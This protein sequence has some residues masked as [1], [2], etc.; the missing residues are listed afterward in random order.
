MDSDE[1]VFPHRLQ[2]DPVLSTAVIL[3]VVLEVKGERRFV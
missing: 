3:A 2:Q 1:T